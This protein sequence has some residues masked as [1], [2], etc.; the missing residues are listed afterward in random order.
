ML[1]PL[2]LRTSLGH[3]EYLFLY[4]TLQTGYIKHLYPTQQ[5]ESLKHLFPT[6][7]PGYLKHLYPTQQPGYLKHLYPTLHLEYHY[8]Y[9][10]VS[11]R[12]CGR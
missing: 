2:L 11:L 5:T 1:R 6:Q 12:D 10:R 4:P 9:Q 3:P 8:L 7:Q